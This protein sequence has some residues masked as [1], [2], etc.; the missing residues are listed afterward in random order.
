MLRLLSLLFLLSAGMVAYAAEPDSCCIDSSATA[1]KDA[2]QELVKQGGTKV[3]GLFTV[4]HIKDSWYLEV[5]DSLVGRMMLA[6]TRF[7]NVP[8]GFKLLSG[9]EVNRSVIY[10]EQ[11]GDKRLLLRE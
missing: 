11:Y 4:R 6:V 5:P 7:A 9:E 8:Q 10:L 2:Y 3:D 1:K